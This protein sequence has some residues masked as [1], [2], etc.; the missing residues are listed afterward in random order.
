MM[1]RRLREEFGVKQAL[2]LLLLC[3][4]AYGACPT[5][6]KDEAALVQAEQMWARA[7]EQ[8]DVQ[9]LGCI[10]ADEFEDADADGNLTDRRATLAKAASH[11]PT[12]HELSDLHAHVHGEFAYIRGLADAMDPQTKMNLRVRFTDIYVFRDGRWQCVAGQESL[13]YAMSH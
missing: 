9:T 6:A 7:L 4:V 8:Q 13:V 11:P 1:V 3:P 5:Q 2:W 12:H 10:L